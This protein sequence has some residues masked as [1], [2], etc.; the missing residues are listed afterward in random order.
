MILRMNA[1]TYRWFLDH[2]QVWWAAQARWAFDR[3]APGIPAIEEDADGEPTGYVVMSHP[4][5]DDRDIYIYRVCEAGMRFAQQ[6]ETRQRGAASALV[7]MQRQ[8]DTEALLAMKAQVDAGR[9]SLS[10]AVDRIWAEVQRQAKTLGVPDYV[11]P[12]V[13]DGLP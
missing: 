3:V 12:A 10:D 9:L 5:I 13:E 11:P 7:E 4:D 8:R 1:D 2:P 6:Q